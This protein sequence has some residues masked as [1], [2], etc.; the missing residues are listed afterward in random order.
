[1]SSLISNPTERTDFVRLHTVVTTCRF[2]DLPVFQITAE[3]LFEHLPVKSICVIAPKTDCRKIAAGL[4]KMITVVAEDEFLPEITIAEMRK[5]I[6][7]H[8]PQAAGWYLQQL[9]KLQFAFQYP[10]DDYYLIW[11]ADTVPLRPLQFFN[12]T[13]QMLL[14]KAKEFH[15]PYFDTY[16]RLVG[17]EPDRSF[18]CIAQHMIIQKS[19]A[20]EML[21]RIHQRV[22]AGKNWAWSIMLNLP[23]QGDNLFSEYETYGH[24][25]KQ[26][27]PERVEFVERRWLREGTRQTGGWIPNANNLQQLSQKYDYVAFERASKDWLQFCR[28]SLKRWL[29]QSRKE[30]DIL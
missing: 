3:K 11:D 16:Q 20:R 13:G 29:K 12:S 18:S 19:I 8:F 9:L 30:M 17:H 24:Y 26:Y 7:P 25:I 21:D 15:P 27:Y 28:M 23:E 1:M 4:D 2:R 22:N 10:E 14:T 6:R 5:I